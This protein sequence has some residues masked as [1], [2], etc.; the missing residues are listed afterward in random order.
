M[1]LQTGGFR[2]AFHLTFIPTDCRQ[3]LWLTVEGW[4]YLV[5]ALL[6][7]VSHLVPAVRDSAGAFQAFDTVL[8]VFSCLA[9]LRLPG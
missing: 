9:L 5:L 2:I 6:E 1:E 8:G 7:M 4:I 3:Y